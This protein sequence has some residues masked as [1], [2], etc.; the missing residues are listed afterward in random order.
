MRSVQD[1]SIPSVL[2]GY[3]QIAVF[4]F[5]HLDCEGLYSEKLLKVFGDIMSWNEI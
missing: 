1:A 5:M 4:L 3:L 2:T